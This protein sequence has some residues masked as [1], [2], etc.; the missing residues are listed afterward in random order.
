MSKESYHLADHV[1]FCGEL[2]CITSEGEEDGWA[3]KIKHLFLW[4]FSQVFAEGGAFPRHYYRPEYW[5]ILKEREKL[6]FKIINEPANTAWY[7][8]SDD[9]ICISLYLLGTFSALYAYQDL[10]PKTLN[11]EF[12]IVDRFLNFLKDE[13]ARQARASELERIIF[14]DPI[15]SCTRGEKQTKISWSHG[16]LLQNFRD[17]QIL[18]GLRLI[19]Q[20]EMAHWHMQ[21]FCDE[22]KKALE[23]E[24]RSCM[25]SC[26]SSDYRQDDIVEYL[27]Q[28]P[29]VI[30]RWTS[31]ISADYLS[32][33]VNLERAKKNGLLKNMFIAIGMYFAVLK[34]EEVKQYRFLHLRES[35]P[36]AVFRELV[37]MHLLAHNYGMSFD[38]F[39]EKMAMSW[40]LISVVLEQACTDVLERK[41]HE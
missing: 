19:F 33:I 36:P 38:D 15:V 12:M 14:H 6:T 9:T 37:V 11:A 24:V 30:E 13:S 5:P 23:E 39:I 20:H 40:M 34:M 8:L 17:D 25:M 28:N 35:H 4:A 2:R 1:I 10:A 18:N 21:K 22:T 27:D 16:E 32:C 29:W 41:C 3:E 26:I 31:E 7:D